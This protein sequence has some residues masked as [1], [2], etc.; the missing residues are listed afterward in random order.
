MF[1]ITVS[2]SL[3]VEHVVDVFE[4]L[5]PTGL[6]LVVQPDDADVPDNTGDLWIRLVDN[7][8]PRWPLSLDVVGGYDCG[9]GPYP[10]LRV[11]EHMGERLGVD[12][13]CGV[14]PS[15]SDVDPS[16]PY[17]RL[18]L[19]GGRWYLASVAFTRLTEP[20]TADSSHDEPVKLI[21]PVVVRTR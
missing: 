14:D 3:T 8:D 12:V 13:L 9:L 5:I 18:A 11:A 21:R 19:V 4:D 17:Y 15:V 16:D 7:E 10:D 6:Q 20:D 2:R 1:S